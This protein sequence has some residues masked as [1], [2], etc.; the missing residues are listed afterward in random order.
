MNVVLLNSLFINIK[1]NCGFNIN[2]KYVYLFYTC[3][4]VC[5]SEF[6][7]LIIGINYILIY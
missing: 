3:V 1:I 6:S 4:S 7:C 5:V 2:T